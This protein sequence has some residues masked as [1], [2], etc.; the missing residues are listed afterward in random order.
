M[1]A[2]ATLLP[3]WDS[4]ARGLIYTILL[5]VIPTVVGS[6]LGVLLAMLLA[7]GRHSPAFW[8]VTALVEVIRGVPPLVWL[9]W[10]YFALPILLDI[11]FDALTAALLVF[12]AIYA[13]FSADIFRGAIAAIPKSTVD[14]A[15]ALGMTRGVVARRVTLTEVM[16]RS[17]AAL[18]G[19]TVGLLKMSSLASIIAVPEL[20]YSFQLILI[21]RPAP[22]EIYTGMAAAYCALVFPTVWFLRRIESSRH[23][24]LNPV[25]G[26]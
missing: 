22:F 10:V 12:T 20:T 19:Q 2:Y 6:A 4:I 23:F 13:A 7:T 5:T 24:T 25:S 11:R 14:S 17:F 21:R 8:L 3:F 15:L 26:A 18:N 16:R 9:V 1:G